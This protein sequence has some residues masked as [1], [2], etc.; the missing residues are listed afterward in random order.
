[1]PLSEEVRCG[2]IPKPDIKF[3]TNDECPN[4]SVLTPTYNRTKFKQLA[5]FN[6]HIMDY[7]K[8]KIEWVILDDGDEPFFTD[9]N[10]LNNCRKY[11]SPIKIHYTYNNSRHMTIGEK[12][13]RLVKMSKTKHLA[14]M[15]DDDIYLPTYLRYSITILKHYKAGLV[16]SPEM[17]FIFPFDGWMTSMIRCGAKR[18][19]H[20]AT[21]VFT[22]KYFNSMS[23]FQKSSQGE[24]AGMVD[25]N[26]RNVVKTECDKIMICVSHK[27]N[28][29]GK[30]REQ[31][32]KNTVT[33][34]SY[35][36]HFQILEDILGIKYIKN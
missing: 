14:F 13:N 28:T 35:L 11:L 26:E 5:A 24:G 12:R 18:Q 6:L 15:D 4:I 36:P 22:K 7:P 8:D 17:Y 27:G 23:G 10:D 2:Q 20:E 25:F 16:G 32:K 9:E 31:F 19:A 21:M 1:M 29:I 34:N 33:L 30:E 3:I